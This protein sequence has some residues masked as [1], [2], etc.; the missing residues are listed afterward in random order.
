[1]HA[2]SD[3]IGDLSGELGSCP[4][5]LSQWILLSNDDLPERDGRREPCQSAGGLTRRE[6]TC[7][8]SGRERNVIALDETKQKIWRREIIV[9]A[10]IDTDTRELIAANP[11]CYRSSI[12]TLVFIKRVIGTCTDRPVILVDGGYGASGPWADTT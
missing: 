10:A 3:G 6:G 8:D 4:H 1:M 12:D 11:S 5:A 7:R 9:R 2:S